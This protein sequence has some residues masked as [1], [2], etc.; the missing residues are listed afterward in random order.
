MIPQEKSAAVTRGLQAA[1]GVTE[2]EEIRQITKG[3]TSALVFRIVVRGHPYLLRIIT[4][5]NSMLG[6]SRHFT[7][8]RIAGEAGIAPHVWYTSLE[9]QISITDF[10]EE[11]AFP[12]AEA[13]VRMPALLRRLHALPPFP[14]GVHHLDTT[15]MFLMHEGPAREGLIQKVR[16]SNALP[17]DDIE[18]LLA[19]HR[20]LS[21]VYPHHRADMVSSH[22]DLFKP[23]NI[24]FDGRRVWLVDWEAAFLN[25]RYADLAV[26]ANLLVANDAEERIYLQEYFGAPPDSY[27]L[28]RFFLMQQLVHMFYTIAFLMF[29]SSGGAVNHGD[30]AAEFT[31]FNRRFWAGEVSLTDQE[32]KFAYGRTHWERLVRNMRGSRFEE[33]SRIVHRRT[34]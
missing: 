7:C 3:R 6:P 28:A 13:L 25:D 31:A 18:Q 24:L 30:K 34:N 17:K 14:E 16:E 27:Q 11:V 26:V 1:F 20:Q 15:C 8:M 23:D 12:A 4:H 21:A 10:V 9:D 5:T 22:N 19:W 2:F 32:T 33:A 29:G